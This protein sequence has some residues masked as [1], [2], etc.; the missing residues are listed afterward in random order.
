MR[1]FILSRRTL[2]DNLQG[3][4][5]MVQLIKCNRDFED[6]TFSE[7]VEFGKNVREYLTTD[8]CFEKLVEEILSL[9]KKLMNK[10]CS[11]LV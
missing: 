6:I 1:T 8:D 9:L 4:V 2:L 7:L 3:D 5:L 10:V 11:S